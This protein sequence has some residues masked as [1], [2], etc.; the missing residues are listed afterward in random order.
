MLREINENMSEKQLVW[1]LVLNSNS[2]VRGCYDDDDV[3]NG[4][5]R[6][7]K[8]K[9]KKGWTRRKRKETSPIAL[10]YNSLT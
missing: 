6:E 1:S 4:R 8:G 2:M 9:E 7:E 3:E 10:R 5:E